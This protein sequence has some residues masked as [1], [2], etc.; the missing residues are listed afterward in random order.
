MTTSNYVDVEINAGGSE[1]VNDTTVDV[2]EFTASEEDGFYINSEEVDTVFLSTN[3]AHNA[4][5]DENTTETWHYQDD[6]GDWHN[7]TASNNADALEVQYKS[8]SYLEIDVLVNVTAGIDI[9]VHA[10]AISGIR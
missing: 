7:V 2:W 5:S 3:L 6:D 9:V 10:S 1:S 8:G 4:N